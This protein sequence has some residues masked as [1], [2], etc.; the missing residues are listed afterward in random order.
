MIKLFLIIWTFL[1]LNLL[2][3]LIFPLYTAAKDLDRLRFEFHLCRVAQDRSKK[4]LY[5]GIHERSFVYQ[6]VFP[7]VFCD[8]D[9][10]F[11][12]NT[13]RVRFGACQDLDEDFDLVVLSGVFNYGS[14]SEEFQRILQHKKFK[15]YLILDWKKNIPFHRSIT[16]EKVEIQNLGRSFYYYY[17]R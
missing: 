7:F 2:K 5:V 15:K 8:M 3:V 17:Q 12:I 10:D 4:I 14:N 9:R 1:R 11:L 13:E 6:L 16:D